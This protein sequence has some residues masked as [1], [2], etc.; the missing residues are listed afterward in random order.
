MH[1]RERVLLQLL[2]LS[3]EA[4]T[5]HQAGGGRRRGLR[6]AATVQE[7]HTQH[8]V[9]HSQTKVGVVWGGRFKIVRVT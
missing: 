5:L 4:E 9:Q 6:A 2:G 1:G 8:S 3:L 7:D